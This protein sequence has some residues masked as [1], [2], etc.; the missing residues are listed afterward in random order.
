MPSD[1]PQP[2]AQDKK[3]PLLLWIVLA[4]VCAAGIALFSFFRSPSHEP[5][6]E[7]LKPE[8]EEAV[9]S[10]I[11]EENLKV[12]GAESPGEPLLPQG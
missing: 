11:Q 12:S 9:F 5:V 2:G 4:L 10:D 1:I 6:K 8:Q 3:V 7:E